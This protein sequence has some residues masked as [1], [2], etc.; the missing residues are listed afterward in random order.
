[1][2]AS[3]S[4]S[5][6]KDTMMPPFPNRRVTKDPIRFAGGAVFEKTA[7]VT[8]LDGGSPTPGSMTEQPCSPFT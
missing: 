4:V 5:C 1:M 8:R 2:V 6:A 3:D 7:V